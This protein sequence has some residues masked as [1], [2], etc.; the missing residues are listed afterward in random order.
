MTIEF[1]GMPGAG[2][3]TVALQAEHYLGYEVIHI[4]SRFELVWRNVIMG[5]L[6][7]IRSAILLIAILKNTGQESGYYKFTNLFLQT[8]A[9]YQKA[10][11]RDRAILDQGSFQNA[12]SLFEIPLSA[13][14]MRRYCAG[15]YKPDML[16][17]FVLPPHLRDE[18]LSGREYIVRTRRGEESFQKR[19]EVMQA[20]FDTVYS[21]LPTLGIPYRVFDAQDSKSVLY[22]NVAAD[23]TEAF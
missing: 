18:R 14:R 4:L 8:N 5:L 16:Y 15:V 23:L 19:L 2:K 6:H 20:N 12:I 22:E 17:V 21:L 3:T 10:N 11:T 7:P 9:K 1:F 13:E